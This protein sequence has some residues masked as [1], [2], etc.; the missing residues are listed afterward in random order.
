MLQAIRERAQGIFAWVM[1]IAVG[2]PFA[3]WG[4]QNY[5]DTGKEAPAAVVG[6]HE[7]FDRDVNRAYDQ[8]LNN[9]VGI[10]DTDEKA[11]R[12]EA[13]ERLINEEVLYQ[14]VERESL[15][16]SDAEV[17]A[18][19]QTLPYFQ[20]DGKF[21]K[22]KYKIMLSS[23]GMSSD[24]FVAQLRRSLAG[25]QFQRSILD[26]E[27]VTQNELDTLLRLKNQQRQ[28]SYFSIPLKPSGHT[29]SDAEVENYFH[30]HAD[31]F[32]TPEKVSIDYILVSL[33]DIAK[34][35]S[36]T[37]EDIRKAYE[38]QKA[39]FGSPE[40]RKISHILIAFDGKGEAA[41]QAALEKAQSIRDRVL[42]GEDFGKL[43]REVSQDSAS[44]QKGGDLGYLNKEAFEST[45]YD[46]ASRLKLAEISEPVKTT[47]GY[48]LIKL[49]EWV[50]AKFKPLED[51]K[52][53]LKKTAQ[54]NAAEAKFYEVGQK[55]AEQ[56][57]EN[58]DSLEGVASGLNLKVQHSGVFTR[59]AG[60][61]IAKE[62]SVRKAAF[63]EE[64]LNGR[65]SDPVE[66][67][68]D[69]ALVLRVRDHELAADKPMNEIKAQILGRLKIEDAWSSTEQQAEKLVQNLKSN[70]QPIADL[71]KASGYALVN[72]GF[73][74]SDAAGVIPQDLIRQVFSAA[75]PTENHP[76]VGRVPMADGSQLVFS[77]SAVKDGE[78]TAKDPK[79]LASSREFL[80][81]AHAQGEYGAFLAELRD[82]TK[83]K[84]KSDK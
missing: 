30:A 20:T 74:R 84:I 61:G 33:D 2:I 8:S 81:R 72:P 48:D 56:A 26:S 65:N 31:Q 4:I 37:E 21:D 42:K 82:Q 3:L 68:N 17:R 29:F 70:G 76:S 64:V 12:Q 67:G 69:K 27:F 51:V 11:L 23:Q 77:V 45:F 7:I 46:A 36:L 49:T 39:S 83:V 41:E 1:L 16:A 13:L 43:A 24:R 57:F 19:I 71:A 5:L 59:D 38:D 9:L 54:H 6:D 55:L 62:E 18:F 79:E 80:R 15:T 52:D 44:A 53:E 47:F 40:K 63:A 50:P 22:E 35:V 14:H 66:L 75:R 73:I 28:F 58:P 32:R 60:E 78:I 25:E 10:G 34:S